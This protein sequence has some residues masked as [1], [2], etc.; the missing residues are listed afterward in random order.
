MVREA[1]RKSVK[2]KE[3]GI[4]NTSLSF[5]ELPLHRLSIANFIVLYLEKKVRNFLSLLHTIFVK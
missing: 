1:Y 2:W 5:H 3:A 4:D